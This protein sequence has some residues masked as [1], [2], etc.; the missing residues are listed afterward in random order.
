[1]IFARMRVREQ[2]ANHAMQRSRACKV[3]Q[4]ESQRSRPADRCRSSDEAGTMELP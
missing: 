3:L 4:M 2:A 1:M